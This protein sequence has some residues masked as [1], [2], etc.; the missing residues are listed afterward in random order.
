MKL[1]IAVGC[2]LIA[3]G[4]VWAG[5]GA[6]YILWPPSSFMLR[7]TEWIFYGATTALAGAGIALYAVWKCR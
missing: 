7:Q 2:G 1:L 4:L 6:G 5:Q 3:L